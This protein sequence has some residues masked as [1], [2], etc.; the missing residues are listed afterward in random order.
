MTF[1]VSVI[2]QKGGVGKTSLAASLFAAKACAGDSAGIIDLDPQ[3][4]ATA[5]AI[6]HAAFNAMDPHAGAEA[7]TLPR[8]EIAKGDSRGITPEQR[9]ELV[10]KHTR[11]CDALKGAL[12]VP[13]NIYMAPASFTDVRL[14]VVPV[15]VLVV[16]TP[17]RLPADVFHAIARQSDVVLAPVVPEA[18]AV[19]NVPDLI[20]ELANGPGAHLFNHNGFRLVVN[21]RQ[22]CANHTAWE[23]VLADHFAEYISRVQIPRATAWGQIM[24]GAKYW[25]TKSVAAKVAAELWDEIGNTHTRR[26]AA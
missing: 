20:R 14:D 3:G 24:N 6:G 15:D 2:Q 23:T 12:V 13:A 16:D 11:R 4:N 17:P 18:M 22:K 8:G 21:M 1:V 7:F 9:A 10:A 5:W 26:A 25:S 19:Q